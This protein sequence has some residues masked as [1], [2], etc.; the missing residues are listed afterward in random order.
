MSVLANE[1]GN[2]KE[3]K[4]LVGYNQSHLSWVQVILEVYAEVVMEA[5]EISTHHDPNNFIAF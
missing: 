3:Q 2:Y 4:D 5:K 1:N